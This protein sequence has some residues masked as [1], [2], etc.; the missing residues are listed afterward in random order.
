M[1]TSNSKETFV[2]KSNITKRSKRVRYIVQE[3]N[4]LFFEIVLG[5]ALESDLSEGEADKE[6]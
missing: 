2:F 4:D 6:A 1:E 3:G 5:P